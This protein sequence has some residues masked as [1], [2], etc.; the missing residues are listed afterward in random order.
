MHALVSEKRGFRERAVEAASAHGHPIAFGE[1]SRPLPIGQ[2]QHLHAADSAASE[3]LDIRRDWECRQGGVAAVDH[4]SQ[5]NPMTSARRAD[6]RWP[7][8]Y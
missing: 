1:L 3:V 7:C 5:N 8:G 6:V 2:A 4:G